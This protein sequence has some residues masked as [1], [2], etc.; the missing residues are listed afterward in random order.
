M[1]IFDFTMM[2]KYI[3]A[4]LAE[5]TNGRFSTISNNN[6][7]S[8]GNTGIIVN[9]NTVPL[10]IVGNTI[11]NNADDGLHVVRHLTIIMATVQP[12]SPGTVS[13]ETFFLPQEA[14]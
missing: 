5:W 10:S 9:N 3:H 11:S 7:S 8:N 1:V 12:L 4:G 13:P 2:G 6:I 14:L